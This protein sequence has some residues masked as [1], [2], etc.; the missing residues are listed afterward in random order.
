MAVLENLEPK[1][2]FHFFEELCKIPHATFDTK[3]ISDYCVEFAKERGLEVSQD[4]TN[5]VIIKKPGTAGYENSEPVILQGHLDMICEKTPD[6]DHDFTKD[7]LDLYVEDGYVRARNT[8]L[9]GDDCIAVAMAM[10]VLDSK[11]I[12]HPPIEAVF[13]VDEELGMGGAEAVDLSQLKGKML[14][15]IDSE[16]EGI[17]TTGCAGGIFYKTVIPMKKEAA[18]GTLVKINIHGLLG[19]H[20]GN[21]IHKQRGNA[22]KMMGRLLYRLG[23]E[24]DLRLT[25]ICGGS[26]DNVIT[27][28][29][30]AG[31]L[32][33]ADQAAKVQEMTDEMRQIWL[34][35]FMG[36]EPT[37]AVD[38]EVTADVHMDAYDK[39]STRRVIA[40]LEVAPNGLQ[41]YSRKLKGIVESSLN[42][43]VVECDD[44][45]VTTQYLIRSSVETRKQ[46]M[47]EQVEQCA[48]LAGG[49][50][51]TT[52]EYPA[53]QFNPDSEL[54]KVMVDIYEKMFGKEPVVS[55][56]HA[57]LEC[58]LF[59]GKRPDLDCVSFGPN[60]LDI[61]SF[62][63]KLDIASTERTWEFLKEIL[64]ELK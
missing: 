40:Y 18:E 43:G 8:S 12:P 58:G 59:L 26:K 34:D 6:S 28:N 35:E 21:E 61:H 55:A 44:T 42:L 51:E 17:L 2:V 22:N 33:P 14:I 53:W 31:V 47:R 39:D 30:S 10:A 7:G 60:I 32:V 56:V 49:K 24:T 46:Q 63:E 64:K 23:K 62:N 25:E 11:D 57:G 16:E 3:R 20:S 41:E 1:Q 5:N 4:D 9:G 52:G 36:E 37:L 29:A 54:R 48:I 15:N 45:S 38:Y 27:M 13:T 19:G 50:G